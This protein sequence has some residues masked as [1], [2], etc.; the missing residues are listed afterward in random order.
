[1]WFVGLSQDLKYYQSGG[2]WSAHLRGGTNTV[3]FLSYYEL[4]PETSESMI[5]TVMIR[6][7]LK[8]LTQSKTD[9]S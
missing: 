7:L 5:Y 1:M 6:L 2:L 9:A 8:R 3:A 4:L